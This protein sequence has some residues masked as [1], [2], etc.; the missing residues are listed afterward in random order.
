MSIERAE[1]LPS[2]TIIAKNEWGTYCVPRSSAHRPAS[3]AILAGKVW[4]KKTLLFMIKHVQDGDIVHAGAFF[5]DFLPALSAALQP[6]A[7]V[8]AFEPNPENFY[9]AQRTVELNNLSNVVLKQVG[10]GNS[11]TVAKLRVAARDGNALGGA[12]RFVS[13]DEPVRSEVL[14]EVPIMRVDDVVPS[15]RKVT[16]LQLDLEGYEF[17]A[18]KGAVETVR[19]CRPLLVLEDNLP[20]SKC[21]GLAESLDYTNIGKL[22]P[23]VIL[24][25]NERAGC[26]AN[27]PPHER[28]SGR[29]EGQ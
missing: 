8:W 14:V 17:V 16:V 3:K 7:R 12:S 10:L 20:I 4:E 15:L 24:A 1:F 2:E 23:N 21:L 9:S 29:A 27:A 28:A 6:E 5:G 25:P 22:G 18:L 26:I 19:R 11:S 13:Y